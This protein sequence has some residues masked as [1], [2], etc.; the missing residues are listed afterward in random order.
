[1]KKTAAVFALGSFVGALATYFVLGFAP[2]LLPFIRMPGSISP[3]PPPVRYSAFWEGYFSSQRPKLVD[4]YRQYENS[5]PMVTADVRYILWRATT[6][7]DCDVRAMYR[8]VAKSDHDVFRRRI[9]GGIL[10]FAGPECGQDGASDFRATARSSKRAGLLAESDIF[11]LLSSRTFEPRF[12]EVPI[13]TS[14]VIPTNAKTMILGDTTIEVPAG[15][16][17]GTQVERVVRDWV[18]YQMKWNLTGDPVPISS[19]LDYH[20]GAVVKRVMELVSVGTYPLAGTVVAQRGEKW[21]APDD[22]GIFRF[23]ILLDKMQYPTTHASGTFGW[24]IDTHGISALVSQALQRRVHLVIGCGDSEGKMKAAIYLAQKGVDV[25]FPGD[26]FLDLLLGYEAKGTLVGTAPVKELG[27][28]VVIGHQPVRF[29][30]QEPIVVEDTNK[31]S[32]PTQ[33]YDAG[34]RYFRRLNEITPLNLH[35]VNVDGANQ[36]GRV[37]ERATQLGSAAVAVRVVE[38]NEYERLRDW[39]N[40]SQRNRAILFHSGLYPY[41]QPLFEEY[42]HQVTFGDLQPRFE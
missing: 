25:V 1:M 15:S 21:F 16:R 33:Y 22:A 37:L 39:L 2:H 10:G 12:E 14:L 17:L 20:E 41:A 35:Y 13:T 9:A 26:R 24:I 4:F 7:P 6:I 42:P 29:L 28:K 32:Y 18:S 3:Q 38:G 23:E 5:D 11:R 30:L 19:I 27:G 36:I 34:A 40:L 8:K 31:A